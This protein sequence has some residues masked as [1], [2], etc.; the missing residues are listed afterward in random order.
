MRRALVW[1]ALLLNPVMLAAQNRVQHEPQSLYKPP[2]QALN[3]CPIQMQAQQRMGD[4]IMTA[5][6]GQR[7][8]TFG[9][10]IRLELADANGVRITGASVRVNGT[11][12]RNRVMQTAP[13]M[14]GPNEV[15]RVMHVEF[16]IQ[17]QLNVSTDLVLAG[18]TS[19]TSIDLLSVNYEDGA[20]W[21]LDQ[22]QF[23]QVRP[24]PVMLITNR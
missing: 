12:A 11:A 3:T 15:T 6:D 17:D 10:R 21:R 16:S 14:A 9:Q 2:P 19:V 18:F 23:C 13:G 22:H 7:L 1:F 24:D 20:S 8:P 5:R 4:H